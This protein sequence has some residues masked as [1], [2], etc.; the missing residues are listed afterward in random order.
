[1]K[2]SGIRINSMAKALNTGQ[3]AL[4]IQ[5]LFNKAR[6][7]VLEYMFSKMVHVTRVK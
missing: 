6:N 1:M 3:M 2:V 5:A 7:K 4:N